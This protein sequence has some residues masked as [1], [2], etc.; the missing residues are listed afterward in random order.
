VRITDLLRDL[1]SEFNSCAPF[2]FLLWAYLPKTYETFMKTDAHNYEIE[3]YQDGSYIHFGLKNKLSE[4]LS[5]LESLHK[6]KFCNQNILQTV[7]IEI[8]HDKIIGY[9]SAITATTLLNYFAF[10]IW[11]CESWK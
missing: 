5:I 1:F 10:G 4:Q 3:H 8:K 7:I 11:I 6:R 9:D 2:V